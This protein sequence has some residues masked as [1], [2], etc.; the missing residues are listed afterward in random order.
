[1][2]RDFPSRTLAIA[3]VCGVCCGLRAAP[4]TAPDFNEVLEVIRAHAS[5]LSEAELNRAAVQGLISA[6]GARASLVTNGAP[7][8]DPARGTLVSR[9]NVF[10]Q[11]IGYLRI[12]RVGEGLA[13]EM[14]NAFQQL[15]G[16]KKLKGVVLD[17][18]YTDGRDYRAAVAA[19]D[20]FLPKAQPL[21]NWGEGAVSSREKQDAI[22]V[23]VA[24]LVNRRTAE[25]AE[26]LAGVLRETGTGLI[27]GGRTAGHAMVMRDFKLKNGQTLR[28]A[29][30]PIMLGDGSKLSVDGLRPDISV[31]VRAEDEQEY[32]ADAFRVLPRSDLLADA[33]LSL[34]NQANG[35]NRARRTRFTE[36]DLVRER[37][38]GQGRD[39]EAAPA[40]E[41][42]PERPIVHD[43]ALAR[44]LDVLKGLAVVRQSRS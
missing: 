23:P 37:R 27:L 44:A 39:L 31:T 38:E 20:L 40:R 36:A 42:E 29:T 19:A 10:D 16:A 28:V 35:T 41:T 26:A 18:R 4:A 17:L 30:A 22:R 11:E 24:V 9:T 32:Y 7:S 43:P 12:A 6:L 34:T 3:L 15:S 8:I 25:A 13:D 1:M 21:L 14:K 2:T 5:G 33:G